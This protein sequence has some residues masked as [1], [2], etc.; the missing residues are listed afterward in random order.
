MSDVVAHNMKKLLL[1]ARGDSFSDGAAIS[2]HP[3]E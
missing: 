2:V 1:L 3:S